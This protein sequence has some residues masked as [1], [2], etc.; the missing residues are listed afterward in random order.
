ML[1]RMP[2]T[3]LQFD[4]LVLDVAAWR[5]IVGPVKS[6]VETNGFEFRM[7]V[8]WEEYAVS[9]VLAIGGSWLAEPVLAL[10]REEHVY[11]IELTPGYWEALRGWMEA[12]GYWDEALLGEKS[13]D[14]SF[15]LDFVDT[16]M[17]TAFLYQQYQRAKAGEDPGYCL[18]EVGLPG[19]VGQPARCLGCGACPDEA[20]RRAI[21]DHQMRHPGRGYL[22]ELETAMRRKWRVQPI[23]GRFSLPPVSGAHGAAWRDALVMRSLLAFDPALVDNLL[24]VRE[25]CFTAGDL[26]RR[27]PP[28]YGEMVV[29][30]KAWDLPALGRALASAEALANGV[31]FLGWLDDYEPG[32]FDRARIRLTLPSEHFPDAGRRLRRFLQD[33]YVPVNLR[34]METGY[35]F[36]V[37]K[38]ARKKRVLL[39]GHFVQG[40]EV[41][42]AELTVTPK[43]DMQA[44][45]DSFPGWGRSLEAQIEVLEL[46]L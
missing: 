3:P 21:T 24:S 43:F 29:A 38:K 19:G 17:D 15:P 34:R 27:Y 26:A 7:A 44:Y 36:D 25:R 35:R 20:V 14:A 2:F 6:T 23:Y 18:G 45:L 46:E 22:R 16:G 11:D 37:P 10:A 5:Q 12:H 39:A 41:F 30:L 1:V 13:A 28:L 8:P 4:R 32:T 33:A 42:E 31:R 9:Q 40:A